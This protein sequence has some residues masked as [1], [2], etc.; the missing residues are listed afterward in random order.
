MGTDKT[1]KDEGNTGFDDSGFT[2]GIK[3]LQTNQTS[4]LNTHHLKLE[5]LDYIDAARALL[6]HW[7]RR[8]YNFLKP[9]FHLTLSF[10][11]RKDFHITIAA[12]ASQHRS[13]TSC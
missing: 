6:H 8:Q 1:I 2:M 10:V 11:G 13:T 7:L 9:Y 4:V 5:P 12:Q 3:S